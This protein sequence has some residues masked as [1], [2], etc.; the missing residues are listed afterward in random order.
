[1]IP[2]YEICVKR[3]KEKKWPIYTRTKHAKEIKSGDKLAF[4]LA[5][6]KKLSQ[7]FVSTGVVNRREESKDN[8]IDIES[9]SGMISSF[10]TLQNIDFLLKPVPI[11]KIIDRLSFITFAGAYGL[12]FQGGCRKFNKSDYELILKYSKQ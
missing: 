6:R 8:L 12:H 10:L 3:L 9:N 7:H 5:G 4:Y 1:M 11:K 2:A